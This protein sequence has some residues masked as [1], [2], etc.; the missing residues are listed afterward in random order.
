M[1]IFVAMATA[2]FFIV[3]NKDKTGTI[4]FRFSYKR[5]KAPFKK[6]TSEIVPLD[7]WDIKKQKVKE[8]ISTATYA[9]KLN[10]RLE[11]IRKKFEEGTKGENISTALL[12]KLWVSIDDK[13]GVSFTE[14][15]RLHYEACK[16]EINPR[17]QR[18]YSTQTLKN[19]HSAMSALE[20]Y[21]K[22][23]GEPTFRDLDESFHSGMISFFKKKGYSPNTSGKY[24]G[25]I[26]TFAR[27]AARKH[28]VHPFILSNEFYLPSGDS[29]T[30]YVPIEE[31]DLI[32]NHEF[33]NERLLN[34]RNWFIIGCW[35]GLRISDWGRVKDFSQDSITITPEK[36][37]HTSGKAVV[38]P[39]HP[40]IRSI[41]ER[42]GMPYKI[43]DQNYNDYIKEVFKEAGITYK[44]E[45]SKMESIGKDAKDREIM[46]KKVGKFPK[47]ELISSHTCRRSFA[48]NNYLMG[49]DTLDIM[50]ITGHTTEKSFLKYIKATPRQHADR[51]RKTWE[52]YYSQQGS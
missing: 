4:Y 44:V 28:P 30:I 2:A 19:Y 38:I 20:E 45:G 18:P 13:K 7:A 46:R 8:K 9:A 22:L 3:K 17:T 37:K 26:K 39:V 50:S 31:I 6:S 24:L 27:E 16:T 40:Q 49:G 21:S 10:K 11:K 48:T 47:N 51:M 29:Q 52:N 43:A 1:I 42:Y 23:K 15:F 5:G 32:F 25:D 41:I 36:T 34:V 14:F 35:T 33:E 12:N